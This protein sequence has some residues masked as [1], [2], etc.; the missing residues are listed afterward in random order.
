VDVMLAAEIKRQD[1]YMTRVGVQ[2][3]NLTLK[4]ESF[5]SVASISI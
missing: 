1:S 4:D 5:A 2:D 3:A